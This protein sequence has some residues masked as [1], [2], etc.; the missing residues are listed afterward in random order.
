STV[1]VA[2]PSR[3]TQ[4][5]T[6]AAAITRSGR[7]GWAQTSWTSAS[8]SMVGRQVRPASVER[9]IPPTWTLTRSTP[10]RVADIERT[11]SG[12]PITLPSTIACPAYHLSRPSTVSKLLR[13]CRAPYDSRR[14]TRASSVPTKTAP[15]V[16]TQH[17][18][19]ES[20]LAIVIHS[21]CADRWRSESPPTIASTPPCPSGVR[22]RTG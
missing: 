13:G 11:P 21:P 17:D 16:A 2:P 14:R 6:A 5:P 19:G 4:R 20:L 8:T 12:G 15:P 18:S 3:L 10:S 9:G 7:V 22:L 1:P